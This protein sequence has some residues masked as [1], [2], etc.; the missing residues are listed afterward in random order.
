[1]GNIRRKVTVSAVPVISF[2]ELS[3][4]PLLKNTDFYAAKRKSVKNASIYV[5]KVIT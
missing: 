1:M 2:N 4:F 3:G 5:Y